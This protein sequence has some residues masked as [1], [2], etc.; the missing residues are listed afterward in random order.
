[1]VNKLLILFMIN[2]TFKIWGSPKLFITNYISKDLMTWFIASRI[3]IMQG[4]QKE[5]N[6]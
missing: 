5:R 4:I 2:E 1:M 3:A 6:R